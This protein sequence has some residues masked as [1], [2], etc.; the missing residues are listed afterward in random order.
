MHI[1]S[2]SGSP[3]SPSRSSALLRAAEQRLAAQ[4]Q[5][6]SHLALRELP[7]Q[8]LVHA[9]TR[10]IMLREAVELVLGA[11][12]VLVATPIYKASYSGLLKL[13]L[14]LLPQDALR[15]KTVLPLATG[16][17]AGHLL[18]LDYAL[19]PVLGALGARHLLDPLFATDAQIAAVGG[20]RY[21]IDPAVLARLDRA[22]EGL[23]DAPRRAPAPRPEAALGA[24]RVP[25]VSSP[26]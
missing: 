21:E 23:F 9:D 7:P 13:F 10:N 19:K 2:L 4:A 15:D 1:V 18:A 3:A 24:R 12:L 11:D 14:D 17:S 8:A 26:A 22:L 20:H 6:T 16:G 25:L 5:S